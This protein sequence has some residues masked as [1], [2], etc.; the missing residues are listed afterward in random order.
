MTREFLLKAGVT[1]FRDKEN[2]V[3][4]VPFERV[5]T[6]EGYCF[7]ILNRLKAREVYCAIHFNRE[8]VVT[9][10][11]GRLHTT[12]IDFSTREEIDI[13]HTLF[14][15]KGM[16][17]PESK[18][19]KREE[20]SIDDDDL[21]FF[22][23]SFE[24]YNE[25]MKQYMY[26][27]EAL[28]IDKKGLLEPI[29]DVYGY[30]SFDLFAQMEQF[31]ILPSYAFIEDII[32]EGVVL[33]NIESSDPINMLHFSHPNK[34]YKQ[35]LF[36]DISFNLIHIS[37]LKTAQ[38]IDALYEFSLKSKAFGIASTPKIEEFADLQEAAALRGQAVKVSL[39][40]CYTR[41]I[42][43]MEKATKLI[44]EVVWKMHNEVAK[45]VSALQ[46]PRQPDV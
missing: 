19:L 4:A 42:E 33:L 1:E 27:S 14:I 2:K 28:T 17:K 46:A 26:S 41:S 18:K 38:F 11:I 3:I 15:Y 31:K 32:N 8:Y 12:T 39:R 5:Y 34:K 10:E 22:A 43:E 16:D 44:K 21:V 13:P 37:R 23:K 6:N 45:E 20:C 29:H 35:T 40:I 25:T 30:T 7:L 36:E 24:G 9:E